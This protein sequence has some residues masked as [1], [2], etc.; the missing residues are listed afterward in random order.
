MT[1]PDP[2]IVGGH[3]ALDFLNTVAAPRGEAIEF[4]PSGAVLLGW[5][6]RTGLIGGREGRHL[7]RRFSSQELDAVARQAIA[8]REWFRPIVRS[9]SAA[10]RRA[11]CG[12]W[13]RPRRTA[14]AGAR[15]R[16]AATARRLR[17]I[18]GD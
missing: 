8:L 13:T 15:W 6:G 16:S 1:L 17:P 2:I 14:G 7:R 9:G 11:R 4:I 18:A 10:T 5:L 3:P 12:S